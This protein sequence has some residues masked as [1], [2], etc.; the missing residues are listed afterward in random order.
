MRERIVTTQVTTASGTTILLLGPTR[1][2]R[3]GKDQECL[4]WGAVMP[5]PP[6][7]PQTSGSVVLGVPVVMETPLGKQGS[8]L[9]VQILPETVVEGSSLAFIRNKDG[10]LDVICSTPVENVEKCEFG[11][12]PDD[13]LKK[14]M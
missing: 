5:V 8:L 2:V 10:R 6:G 11:P 7:T 9:P 1:Y 3:N 4:A 13:V 12:L 14:L